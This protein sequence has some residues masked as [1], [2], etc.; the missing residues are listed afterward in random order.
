MLL[1]HEFLFLSN[2]FY[3]LMKRRLQIGEKEA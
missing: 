1:E 3:V 2:K